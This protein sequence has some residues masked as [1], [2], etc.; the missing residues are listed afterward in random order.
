MESLAPADALDLVGGGLDPEALGTLAG[1]PVIVVS[2]DDTPATARCAQ[3]LVRIPCVTIGVDFPGS[4]P[5]SAEGFDIL[6]TT[7]P[8]PPAPW[9][10]SGPQAML[11]DLELAVSRSP[12]ASVALVQLLRLGTALDTGSALVAESLAYGLLQSGSGFGRWLAERT[13]PAR[14]AEDHG[15]A[16]LA[17]RSGAT[18]RLTLNRPSVHNAYSAAMRDALVEG[19]ALAAADL[20]IKSVELSGAGP[21][22]CSGGDLTE[23][24]ATPDPVTGHLVRS[25]RHP[26]WWLAELGPKTSAFVHGSCVGAGVELPAFAGRVVAHPDTTFRLP[27]VEMGLIP[28]AGGTAS[29]PRRIGRHRTAYLAL[30][31]KAIDAATAL[32]W[33]LVDEIGSGSPD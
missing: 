5:L 4:V 20:T 26:A 24:G 29:L 8:E 16:V 9:L 1:R 25:T 27:E 23:F 3:L 22:F 2:V 19:L 6:L 33:G 18:L 11:A 30:T 32:S 31:G 14:P 21:S 28:G 7:R 12:E 10:G 15:P 13:A 17:D